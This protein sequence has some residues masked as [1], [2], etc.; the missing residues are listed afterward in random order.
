MKYYKVKARGLTHERH[1]QSEYHI[2]TGDKRM[3][4][5]AHFGSPTIQTKVIDTLTITDV[6][7]MIENDDGLCGGCK[8]CLLAETGKYYIGDCYAH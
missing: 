4:C 6:V 5:G 7:D 2:G 3:L 1:L 8:R